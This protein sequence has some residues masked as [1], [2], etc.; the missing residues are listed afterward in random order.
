MVRIF[1]MDA[2]GDIHLPP[3]IR[4]SECLAM[5]AGGLRAMAGHPVELFR[6]RGGSMLS[7]GMR[8]HDLGLFSIDDIAGLVGA[9]RGAGFDAIQLAPRRLFRD[10][11]ETPTAAQAGALGA[12]LREAGIRV[13]VLGCYIDP[14]HPDEA[15]RAASISRFLSDIRLCRQYGA[16]VM[17]TETGRP[18]NPYQRAGARAGMPNSGAEREFDILAGSFRILAAAARDEGVRIAVEPVWEHILSTPRLARELLD[19]VGNPALGLLLD[20]CNLVSPTICEAGSGA[21][22]AT[23]TVN[24]LAGPALE[25][26]DLLGDDLFAMHAKD[27]LYGGGAKQGAT[28]GEGIM[29][30]KSVLRAYETRI[31]ASRRIPLII[32][33]HLPGSHSRARDFLSDLMT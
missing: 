4:E 23:S 14:A 13:E 17:A 19:A 20:P 25:A 1:A 6:T 9:V 29:D 3:L 2:C 22:S 15:V 7:W 24:G 33:E 30:W 21:S 28:C 16:S 31:P 12:S 10:C 5:Y 32:E 11:P 26:L 8:A 18:W 27:F